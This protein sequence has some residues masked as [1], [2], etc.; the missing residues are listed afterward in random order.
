VKIRR[1]FYPFAFGEVDMSLE[2][3]WLYVIAVFVVAGTPGP[4]MLHIM[5]RSVQFGFRTSIYAMLGC[6]S[7]VLIYL[8]ASALGLG[9]VLKA[10]PHL[11]D[12][13]RYTGAAYLIWLGIKAWRSPATPAGSAD[14]ATGPARMSP[15]AIYRGGLLVSL[16]NPKL[17]MFAAALFPQFIDPKTPFA[18]QLA[19]LVVSFLFIE[20]FWY[21]I[22][23]KGGQRLSAWLRHANRQRTFDRAAGSAFV[24]FGGILLASRG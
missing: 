16:S 3:W 18:P 14:N 15:S 11:F 17:I 9:A 10:L 4:N 8:F 24:G 12:A 7:A 22:Y 5:S 1:L 20:C 6:V 13:L 2:N 21:V 23:A 19:I